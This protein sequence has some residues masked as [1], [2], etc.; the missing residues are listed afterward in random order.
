M[1]NKL[2]D[3]NDHLFCGRERLR[4]ENL[5]DDGLQAEIGRT[6]AICGG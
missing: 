1:K 3:L 6:N 4:D 2:G 5:K